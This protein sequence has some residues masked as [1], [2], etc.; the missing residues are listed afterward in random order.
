MDGCSEFAA[1]IAVRTAVRA[2]ACIRRGRSDSAP[3]CFKAATTSRSCSSRGFP[4]DGMTRAFK[5]R[6]RAVAIPGASGRLEITTEMRV[7]GIR[8]ASMLSAIATKF[9]PRPERRIPSECMGDFGNHHNPGFTAEARS[10]TETVKDE[11]LCLLSQTGRRSRRYLEREVLAMKKWLRRSAFLLLTVLIVAGPG[12]RLGL[13][14]WCLRWGTTPAEA[15]ATLPGDDLFPVYAS[16]ATHAITIQTP[17]QKIWPWLMQIGRIAADSTATRFSKT[18]LGATC[19]RLSIWFQSGRLA[20]R[21]RP[22]GSAIRSASTGEGKIDST[23]VEPDRH[24]RW[25]P[26]PTG[27]ACQTGTRAQESL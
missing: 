5:P 10:H 19:P 2:I 6:S 26:R 12:Y 3:L 9:E 25:S 14:N 8:P 11:L 18:D 17:P 4:L 21:V 1:E 13:H 23:I 7:S 22:S 27:E 15:R 16:E 24:L 20:I